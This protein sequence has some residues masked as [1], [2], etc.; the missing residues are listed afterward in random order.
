MISFG[1]TMYSTKRS[2]QY[3]GRPVMSSSSKSATTS[4]LLGLLLHPRPVFVVGLFLLGTA[5]KLLLL[6]RTGGLVGR[7]A[8]AGARRAC[9]DMRAF[10]GGLIAVYAS[11]QA[12][13][14]RLESP[15]KWS[16]RC[17][18]DLQT[19]SAGISMLAASLSQI[20]NVSSN[21]D[22]EM[23]VYNRVTMQ[24]TRQIHHLVRTKENG[25]L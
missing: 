25:A 22:T 4:R 12:K 9:K 5:V 24:I 21:P 15:C 11:A 18:S 3:C 6:V 13:L 14:Y 16:T 8:C 7:L 23:N 20:S 10:C 1:T 17:G 19:T 2:H